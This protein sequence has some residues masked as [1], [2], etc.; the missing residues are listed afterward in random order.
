VIDDAP[1]RK[2]LGDA[3]NPAHTEWQR[4]SKKF[5]GKYEYGPSVLDFVKSAVREVVSLLTPTPTE[6]HRSLLDDVFYVDELP[7]EDEPP[8]DGKRKPD[9]PEPP[10]PPPPPAEPKPYALVQTPGGFKVHA[11]PG[12]GTTPKLLRILTAYRVRRGNPFARYNELDFDLASPPIDVQ[13]IQAEIRARSRNEL[14]LKITGDDFCVT[15]TGFDT[16][17]DLRVSVTDVGGNE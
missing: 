10:P 13:V 1:L 9:G 17:R 16:L 8:D 12:H 11:N 4:D 15:V 6:L 7:D 3:E 2:L 5:K 14:S